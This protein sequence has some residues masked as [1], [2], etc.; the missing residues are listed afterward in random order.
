MSG[1]VW[2]LQRKV[3]IYAV[4]VRWLQPWKEN[5]KF[6]TLGAG[7]FHKPIYYG[8]YSLL[9]DSFF[10]TIIFIL[11]RSRVEVN[12]EGKQVLVGTGCHRTLFTGTEWLTVPATSEY[13]Q[14]GEFWGEFAQA[15]F[16]SEFC[17]TA[18]LGLV[19]ILEQK[20]DFCCL[21]LA[22]I[23]YS[24]QEIQQYDQ[25]MSQHRLL[26]VLTPRKPLL[27][28]GQCFFFKNSTSSVEHTN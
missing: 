6:E 13:F 21:I 28:S 12:L 10:R 27:Y 23:L 8:C 17:F 2:R 18:I 11:F 4:T 26:T 3:I 15:W 16:S 19:A 24:F 5:R 1:D 22:N 7:G 9:Q 20:H 25:G 14:G